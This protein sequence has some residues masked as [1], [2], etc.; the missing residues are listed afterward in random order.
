MAMIISVDLVLVGNG[1]RLQ[2]GIFCAQKYCYNSSFP[3][4]IYFKDYTI[5][6]FIYLIESQM[7][8]REHY[9]FMILFLSQHLVAK[10]SLSAGLTIFLHIL[11]YLFSCCGLC[12]CILDVMGNIL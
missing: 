10:L 1:C 5:S 11:C 9:L 3:F 12:S 7:L 2:L 4:S 8:I 6:S